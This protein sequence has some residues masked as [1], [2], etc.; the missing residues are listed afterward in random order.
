MFRDEKYH[1]LVKEYSNHIQKKLEFY[2]CFVKGGGDDT[3]DHFSSVRVS[4]AFRTRT[5]KLRLPTQETWEG[6][7]KNL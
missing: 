2:N 3:P 6:I 1:R 5:A 7:G 4:K